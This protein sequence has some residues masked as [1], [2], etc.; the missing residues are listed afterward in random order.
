MVV[1]VNVWPD[2][3]DT[4]NLNSVYSNDEESNAFDKINRK[5]NRKINRL[6]SRRRSTRNLKSK[7]G[8]KLN[9]IA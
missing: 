5:V 6:S 3:K 9:G 2:E 1:P 4:L 8:I 7:F